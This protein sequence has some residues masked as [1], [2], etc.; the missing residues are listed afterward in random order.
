MGTV[1]LQGAQVP[2]AHPCVQRV[3]AWSHSKAELPACSCWHSFPSLCSPEDA[4]SWLRKKWCPALKCA[5]LNDLCIFYQ[6]PGICSPDL[7]LLLSFRPGVCVTASGL[8]GCSPLPWMRPA[9]VA[10]ASTGPRTTPEV[11]HPRCLDGGSSGL[12]P[13]WAQVPSDLTMGCGVW[14][15]SPTPQCQPTLFRDLSR[16]QPPTIAAFSPISLRGR[17]LRTLSC[18]KIGFLPQQICHSLQES[19]RVGTGILCPGHAWHWTGTGGISVPPIA[20]SIAEESEALGANRACLGMS[21]G[22]SADQPIISDRQAL[23]PS[24]QGLKMS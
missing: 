6:L 9:P 23:G 15:R 20:I 10:S 24:S 22:I 2:G 17:A 14:W 7:S 19:S 11:S 21:C 4:L 5:L 16:A 3:G 1:L 8:A 18:W 12:L 13:C